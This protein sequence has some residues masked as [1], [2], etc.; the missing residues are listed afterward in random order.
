MPSKITSVVINDG[1]KILGIQGSYKYKPDD[2]PSFTQKESIE[3]LNDKEKVDIL[4][5]HD[6]P[7]GLSGR[8][9]VA[10]QGLF[11]TLYYLF[12]NKT[13][14]CIHGHLHTPYTKEM[15]NE[16]KANLLNTLNQKDLKA[17]NDENEL[18]G[19]I[20]RSLKNYIYM[21]K[22]AAVPAV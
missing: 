17:L 15:I 11:G 13:P 8:N 20:R 21:Q 18:S 4:V 3:F 14:Y 1:V 16:A 6:A 2:F 7:Y 22:I 19:I 10:H 12:K 5:C 9:D